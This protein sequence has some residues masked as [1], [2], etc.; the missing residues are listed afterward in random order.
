MVAF[1]RQVLV[2]VVLPRQVQARVL[3]VLCLA[4][5]LLEVLVQVAFQD[6]DKPARMARQLKPRLNG[7]LTPTH[8]TRSHIGEVSDSICAG[9]S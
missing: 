9:F 8:F 7:M 6:K 4:E 5:Q 3:L 1:L 2:Q